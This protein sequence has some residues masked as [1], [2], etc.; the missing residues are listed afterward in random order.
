MLADEIYEKLCYNGVKPFSIAKCSDKMK[1]LTITVNGVSKSYAM[2][3][4]RIGYL[5]APLD[6]A[7]AIDSFQSH[8]TSNASSISQY[9]TLEALSAPEEEVQAMVDIFDKRRAKL[10]DL[11]AGIDGVSA[12]EPDGAFYV[13][14]VVDGLYGKMYNEKVIDGSITFAALLLEAEKV[15][16]I[17]GISFGADDC[18]RLS[19]ALSDEDIEEGLMRIKRFVSALE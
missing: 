15:A 17:P 3:G 8:A 14:M 6:V 13:M 12:V 11:I 10:L 9:A 7:K 16:T 18:L 2:T 1:D 4:W 19:Y 5:A